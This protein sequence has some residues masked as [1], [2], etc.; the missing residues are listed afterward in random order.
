M[1]KSVLMKLRPSYPNH[2]LT[3]LALFFSI[4]LITLSI[5]S[6]VHAAS[7]DVYVAPSGNDANPGTV[8]KPLASLQA[9]RDTLRS[10][11]KL[12]KQPCR[13]ILQGGVYRLSKALQL[14]PQDGGAK[15]AAVVYMAAK[16]AE[17]TLTGAQ[18]LDLKWEPWKAAGRT[19]G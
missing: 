17:V 1:F 12:G 11:A 14:I 5:T 13:V 9:A 8:D 6:A 18:K 4:G 3:Q 15:G 10:S 16:G 2:K 19:T 7:Y